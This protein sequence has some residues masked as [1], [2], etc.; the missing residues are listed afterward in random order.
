MTTIG[1]WLH[2]LWNGTCV[3]TDDSGNRYYVERRPAK[4]AAVRRWVIYEGEPQ[5]SKVPPRWHA[6][7]HYLTDKLPDE[8]ET[9][10]R[11]WQQPHQPNLTGTEAAYRPTGSELRE[12]PRA[13]GTGDYEPWVPS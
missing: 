2:T 10:E 7:L 13:R 4:G 12:G 6:W 11:P 3:G 8:Q 9:P 1:T 5:A